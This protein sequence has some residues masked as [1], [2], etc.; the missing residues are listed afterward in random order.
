M[1][2]F[3]YTLMTEQNGPNDL[4]RYAVAAG[5]RD[6]DFEVCSDHFA[7]WLTEQGHAPNVWVPWR[8]PPSGSRCT[9]LSPVRPSAITPWSSR[10]RPPPCSCCPTAGSPWGWAAVRTSTNT[11]SATAGRPCN[12]A[13]RCC[14][15][16][17]RSSGLC[18]R[19]GPVSHGGNYFRVDYFRVDA[20]RLWNPPATPI[21]IGVA[22]AGFTDIAL[23]QIGGETQE[24][25]LDE[26]AEPLLTPLRAAAG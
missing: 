2:R 14:G 4:V 26:V 17:S 15:K 19:G 1:V 8:T 23:R 20:A 18:W 5:G 7:P 11:S 3:G 25:F 12:A 24:R 13:T 21:G 16:P 10:S 6:F 9:R 22:M